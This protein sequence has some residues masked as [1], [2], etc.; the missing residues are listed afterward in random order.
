[1]THDGLGKY[2]SRIVEKASL[3]EM[4]SCALSFG[5]IVMEYLAS[6]ELGFFIVQAPGGQPSLVACK[7]GKPSVLDNSVIP[8]VLA[9]SGSRVL[10]LKENAS[11]SSSSTATR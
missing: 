11:A 3:D 1:M 6:P 4:R 5:N 8:S 9:A 10:Y 2:L 7:E